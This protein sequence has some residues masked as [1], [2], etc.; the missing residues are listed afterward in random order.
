M[1]VA[2]LV[3]E[4]AITPPHDPGLASTSGGLGADEYASTS[5]AANPPIDDGTPT[6]ASVA[7]DDVVVPEASESEAVAIDGKELWRLSVFD[8]PTPDMTG[9]S[10]LRKLAGCDFSYEILDVSRWERRDFLARSYRQGRVLIAGDAAHEMSPTGGSGMHTGICESVNLAWKIAALYEGWGGPR[11]LDSYEAECRPIA[12]YYVDLS[13]T[14]FNAISALPGASAFP[15]AVAGDNDLLRQLSTPDQYRAQFCYENSPIC[16]PDGTRAPEGVER[17][18][19]SARPGTRAPHCRIGK[20]QSMLDLFGNGFVL[21]RFGSR[22]VA[23]REIEP[24]IAAAAERGV[25]L[26]IANIDHREAAT[27]YEKKLVLVRPDGHVAWRGDAI[28]DDAMAL[29]DHVRGA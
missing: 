4:P 12:Q 6:G 8:D 10:Y 5:A 19:P 7:A 24:L 3:G 15:D 2:E 23:D 17:L 11:L 26:E 14:S 18:V 21:V 20:N 25:P 22:D 16:V 28:P 13:T 29:L 9:V 1:V 27:I